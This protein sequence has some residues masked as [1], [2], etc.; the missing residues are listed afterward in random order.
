MALRQILRWDEA[1]LVR[2][3]GWQRPSLTRVLRGVTHLGDGLSWAFIGLVLMMLGSERAEQIGRALLLSSAGAAVVSQAVKRVSKRRRPSEGIAGFS[4]LVANPDAFSFP[5]GHTAAAVAVAIA[6][7]GFGGPL[8]V[9]FGALAV[10]VGFSRVYLGAHYP[11]DVAAGAV[12][13]IAVGVAVNAGL[14]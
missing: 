13:G 6:C 5:S 12:I 7:S 3:V 9:L 10:L 11:L 4:A 1:A 8:A 14:G 2:V